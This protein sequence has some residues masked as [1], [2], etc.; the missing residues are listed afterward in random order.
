M[1]MPSR[2]LPYDSKMKK[3]EQLSIRASHENL[4]EI[5]VPIYP[6]PPLLIVA[7]DPNWK[8][9]L[10]S[11]AFI[12]LAVWLRRSRANRNLPPSV[13]GLSLLG[14]THLQLD[15]WKNQHGPIYS[16]NA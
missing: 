13:P 3:G 2:P 4:R 8:T 7:M 9:T 15:E 5:T 16:L 1:V 6:R 10:V 11:G 14:N 12:A